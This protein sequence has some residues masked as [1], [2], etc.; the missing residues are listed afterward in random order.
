MENVKTL[1]VKKLLIIALCSVLS[2]ISLLPVF[3]FRSRAEDATDGRS[4]S[5]ADVSNPLLVLNPYTEMPRAFAAT[6]RFDG[7]VDT[8][9]PIISNLK[10]DT[11]RHRSFEITSEGK[12]A[13]SNYYKFDGMQRYEYIEKTSYVEFNYSV[14]G[15]GE[16]HLVA[17]D[18]IVDGK[19]VYKL[20]ANGELVD[21]VTKYPYVYN[22]DMYVLQ[23]T[24]PYSI[25]CDAKNYFSGV[26]KDVAVYSDALTADEAAS[27]YANGVDV[28]HSDIMAYY[29]LTS[30]DN[31][32]R[33]IKDQTGNGHDASDLFENSKYSANDYAYSIAV[34]GDTQKL[35]IKDVNDGTDYT[36]YI[37][38]W[39][40]QNK[41]EKNI[42]FVMGLGDVTD[43]NLSTEWQLVADLHNKLEAINLPYSVIQGNHD[44]V[45]QL[46]KFFK[47]KENFTNAVKNGTIGY[48]SEDSLANYY[49]TFT[50]K[51]K[52]GNETGN[53][54]LVLN[55]ECKVPDT[56]I[57]WA[58]QVIEQH[59]DYQVIINTHEYAQFP[60]AYFM[61][62]YPT[63]DEGVA[64]D[65]YQIWMKLA[66][67]HENVIIVLSG[68]LSIPTISMKNPVVGVNGNT[69]Y[70]FLIDPQQFDREQG[71]ETGMVAMFYFSADGK[72]VK[73]EY[74]STY[75]S[76]K[77]A[78]LDETAPDVISNPYM[79]NHTLDIGKKVTLSDVECEY[80]TIPAAYANANTYPFVVFKPDKSFVGGYFD[81]GD[82]MKA[83]VEI[84]ASADYNVLMRRDAEQYYS[85]DV[86]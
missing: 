81:L 84:D 34:I 12:P 72:T 4:F 50:A 11:T 86:S 60:D 27:V 24:R 26:I 7:G 28:K 63:V 45:K 3:S 14:I 41:D 32:D 18:E 42:Q 29:D 43:E 79:S 39:I 6:V 64:N 61:H 78:E 73:T 65:P 57:P 66:S 16:V 2:I 44:T 38:E 25:G 21:T 49:M 47:D 56:V 22:Q 23:R 10:S 33:F 48:F 5:A 37:Y 13:I 76:L 31:T 20:Y 15:K 8:A 19:S 55:L 1:S 69:V 70:E 54:Y 52:N 71:Y 46:D 82:V 36:S 40:A 51:D 68:H 85:S 58:N 9:S 59:S 53:K 77:A 35:T 80:G 67:Q 83:M 74:V 30:S 62:R 75:K 17:V